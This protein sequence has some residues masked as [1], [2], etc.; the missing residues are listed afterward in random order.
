MRAREDAPVRA[1]EAGAEGLELL[2]FG[3]RHDGDGD[4]RRR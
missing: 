2:A 3:A 1:F 4:H